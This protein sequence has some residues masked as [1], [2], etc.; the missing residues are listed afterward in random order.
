MGDGILSQFNS[1]LDAVN[2]AIEIQKS[3]R[4]E[5]DAKLRIG[6]HSGDITIENNDV[7]GDGVNVASRLESI[8]DPG[9]IYISESIEKAI[10][11]HSNIQAK[12]LGEIQLKNV[13]YDVGTYALQGVG[14]PLPDLKENKN[15]S[16]RF[17]AEVKRRGV[18]RTG[19]M[20]IIL[21][22]LLILLL[23][24]AKSLIN[25]PSWSSTVFYIILIAG[26][27]IAI[28]FAWNYERSPQ[29]LV[30]TTSKES[31]RNPY[32]N[33]QRKP[34]TGNVIIAVLL[35]ILIITY[36]N[37]GFLPESNSMESGTA[38]NSIA[39][40]PFINDSPDPDN[41]YLA[42]GIMDELIMDLQKVASL[43]VTPRASIEKYR[44]SNAGS[45]E[46]GDELGVSY[47][48]SG[49]IRRAGDSL[50]IKV[51]LIDVDQDNN[52][53]SDTYNKKY[54][55]K[56]FAFQI[57]LAKNI[58]SQVHAFITPHEK[59]RLENTQP[60]SFEAYDL[61]L[62]GQQM[63]QEFH[64]T[65]DSTY[66]W[67][68]HHL[69]NEALKYD[70]TY[71]K[72][73]DGKRAYF[74]R[75]VQ[76]DSALYF[77]D[78]I[79]ALY[80]DE[81]EGYVGKGNVWLR[82]GKPDSALNY[83]SIAEKIKPNDLWVNIQMGLAYWG[84]DEYKKALNYFQKAY[85]LTDNPP[86]DLG[87]FT[88]RLFLHI[89]EY[90]RAEK[91]LKESF[92]INSL[93]YH[94]YWINMTYLA[95]GK[96]DQATHFLDSVCN[97]TP[98]M[99]Y[100]NRERFRI[101]FSKKD[102]KNAELNYDEEFDITLID[103]TTWGNLF[104][105]RISKAWIYFKT[106]RKEEAKKILENI[107]LEDKE[108]L[109]EDPTWPKKRY[110]RLAAAYAIKGEDQISLKYLKEL[111]RIGFLDEWHYYIEFYPP[112]E[113]LKSDPEFKAIVRKAQEKKATYRAQIREM[114]ERG[115]LNL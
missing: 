45:R 80:P 1:A 6:I 114:E 48:V 111:E 94:I 39:V 18:V 74:V 99:E 88:G 71:I 31:W 37:P 67:T 58:A 50:R 109:K 59:T 20:Y 69:F 82:L 30:R 85:E 35:L 23:P 17:F 53:W 86:Y 76:Y 78:K 21:S 105:D 84:K 11:G 29:G 73:L 104:M 27:P 77:C 5:L 107:I 90:S 15:L 66:L 4:A 63:L 64:S 40:L 32:K 98:C 97:I 101:F 41:V 100:C 102:Y 89:G 42:N 106:E 81:A 8:C 57:N 95:Q 96:F 14:L 26:F 12:Y 87:Y 33:S 115:Q 72:A 43:R 83:L 103:R 62:R 36:L 10:R 47:L 3:A 91:Y 19:I 25:L 68:A 113:Q 46:I 79:I 38:D 70:S 7:Y 22:L 112:F 92:N 9:G 2:C 110:L 55:T 60:T 54:T 44:D 108:S 93:C 16:G 51:E 75:S 52:I 61:S 13:D 65:F 28:F 34:L 56:V 49:S 24:Y